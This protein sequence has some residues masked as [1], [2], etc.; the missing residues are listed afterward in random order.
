MCVL[1]NACEWVWPR[2]TSVPRAPVKVR[3]QL[4]VWVF[5]FTSLL[6]SC[7]SLLYKPDWFPGSFWGFS[8][9]C[10]PS[11]WR[12]SRIKQLHYRSFYSILLLRG[13]LNSGFKPEGQAPLPIQPDLLS[14]SFI[15][16]FI[17][18]DKHLL[19]R[20][21]WNFPNIIELWLP[22]QQFL[23]SQERKV[24]LFT[25]RRVVPL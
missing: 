4:W 13:N 6:L 8:S 2:D 17:I 3:R 25:S 19:W 5:H 22:G 9:L 7:C 24:S 10:L 18:V 23:S 15:F 14:S 21:L 11:P 12:S 1:V 20:M 16:I